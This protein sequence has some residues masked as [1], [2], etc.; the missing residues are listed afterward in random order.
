MYKIILVDDESMVLKSLKASVDWESYGFE[1][2]DCA[3]SAR[4]ALEKIELHKPDVVLTDIRMPEISGL[5]LLQMIKASCPGVACLVISGY[6]EFAYIQKAVKLEAVGYCLKPFDYDEIT[7]Y[8]KKIKKSL[9]AMQEEYGRD[10]LLEYLESRS[11]EAKKYVN[12]F[13]LNNGIDFMRDEIKAVYVLGEIKGGEENGMLSLSAGYLKQIFFIQKEQEEI[14]LKH[15]TDAQGGAP[16]KVNYIGISRKIE[17]ITKVGK[18]LQEAKKQAYQHFC[19]PD[20]RICDFMPADRN[21]YLI[22]QLGP[23]IHRGNQENVKEKTKKLREEF[24]RGNFSIDAGILLHNLIG[25][26]QDER[27]DQMDVQFFWDYDTLCEEYGNA[28]QMLDYLEELLCMREKEREEY[29]EITNQ[30]FLGIKTYV[31]ENFREHMT[32]VDISRKF[33]INQCYVS[34]LFRKETGKTFTDFLTEKR[35]SYACSLLEQNPGSIAEVAE[36]SGFS[37]YYYFSRVFRKVMHCTP[38]EYRK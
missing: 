36:K 38:S 25:T 22:T 31:E 14:F 1:V 5:E 7:L 30:T 2:V 19:Q 37:E 23:N 29:K 24:R 35:I 18:V 13:F 20:R 26:W 12:S 16:E 21:L 32:A 9:D 27:E 8:L 17:D 33:H 11:D 6:A 15:L 4:E 28:D 34:H 10:V 3:T